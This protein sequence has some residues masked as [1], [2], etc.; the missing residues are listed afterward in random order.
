MTFT[1]L[2]ALAAWAASTPPDSTPSRLHLGFNPVG[3][4]TTRIEL[5]SQYNLASRFGV[6]A[7]VGFDHSQQARRPKNL[8]ANAVWGPYV[9]VGPW[10]DLIRTDGGSRLR[11]QVMVGRCAMNHVFRVRIRTYYEDFVDE[12]RTYVG[13]N[14][15]RGQLA[16]I[17]QAGSLQVHLGTAANFW[18]PRRDG[19]SESGFWQVPGV[20]YECFLRDTSYL[21]GSTVRQLDRAN[22]HGWSIHPIVHL[23]WSVGR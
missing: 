6:A 8:E 22:E 20:S 3:I 21:D 15:M 9:M 10:A 16:Y 11:A 5:T 13:I 4:L 7:H 12:Q 23:A 18:R 2:I 1:T 17:I 19:L 14:A